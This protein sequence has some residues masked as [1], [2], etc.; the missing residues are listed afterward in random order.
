[1]Q[2]VD[3]QI[4]QARDALAQDEKNA[5]R[6]ETTDLDKTHALLQEELARARAELAT[7]KGRSA[8]IEK[9]VAV[10]QESARQLNRKEI[11][12][13]DLVRSAKTAEDNYLLY[14][15]KQEEARISDALD[16]KRIVN[17]AVAEEATVPAFPSSPKWP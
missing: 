17:V 3:Q 10:Y 16:R 9:S 13:Q 7:L 12:H 1:M 5:L 11:V 6:D 4:A 8:E 14:L 2:E 15:R